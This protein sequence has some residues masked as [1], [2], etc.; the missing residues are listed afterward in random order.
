MTN[1]FP[2]GW[3]LGSTGIFLFVIAGSIITFF[4][5]RRCNN[6]NGN[7]NGNQNCWTVIFR[8]RQGEEDAAL[9]R[10]ADQNGSGQNGQNGSGQIQHQAVIHNNGSESENDDETGSDEGTHYSPPPPYCP[11][12]PPASPLVN[13]GPLVRE[14]RVE[15]M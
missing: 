2:Y 8:R 1:G 5:V 4:L 3:V 14:D 13:L 11:T 7:G 6:T 9:L 12:A 10:G 15:R